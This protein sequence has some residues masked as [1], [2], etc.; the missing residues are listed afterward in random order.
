MKNTLVFIS[1]TLFFYSCKNETG[2]SFS[3]TGELKNAGSAMVYLE[4]TPLG[5]GQRIVVDSSS[6]ENGSFSLK[7]KAGEESLFSLYVKNETYPFAFVINDASN[8]KVTADLSQRSN[9]KVEGSPTTTSLR[10][11][12]DRASDKY[13][14]LY[15]LGQR[16]DSLQRSGASDSLLLALDNQGNVL[17]SELQSE[18]RKFIQASSSPVS[19]FVI[20]NNYQQLFTG[21]EYQKLLND[22]VRKFPEHS[23]VIAIKETN[24]REISRRQQEQ[25][26]AG[27]QWVGKE[28][29]ELSLPGIDDRE[30]SLTSFRGKYVLVDFWASWCAPCRAENPNVV[31][32]YNKFRDKNFTILGVS[33][34]KTKDEWLKAIQR[35]KLA[36]THVSD[37]KYWSSIAV[38]TYN[39]DQIPFNVLVNPS[40]KV[41]AQDLR[42]GE[43]EATLAELLR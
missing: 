31:R 4:E 25:K 14:Q 6:I 27:P 22:I 5:S 13:S 37:L 32:A 24:D 21:N 15:F 36:W 40:G 38:P 26:Q 30:I 35:D 43:L 19:S 20:L 8:I 2:K 9:Y 42:G 16:R 23:G 17:W 11:F 34:D 7:G 12:S 39:L 18:I 1:I 10:E 29:P 41:I 3:V 28:A 33:L